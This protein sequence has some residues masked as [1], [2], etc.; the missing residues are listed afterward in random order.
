MND[1]RKLKPEEVLRYFE[2]A[3][4]SQATINVGAGNGNY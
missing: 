3:H 4:L 1:K 2:E